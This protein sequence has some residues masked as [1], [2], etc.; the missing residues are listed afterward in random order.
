MGSL[1]SFDEK[2]WLA[3][4][5]LLQQIYYKYIQFWYLWEKKSFP[6]ISLSM[7]QNIIKQNFGNPYDFEC[8]SECEDG[9]R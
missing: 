9:I 2:S 1:I 4:N 5:D 7:I 3:I 8:P 6:T